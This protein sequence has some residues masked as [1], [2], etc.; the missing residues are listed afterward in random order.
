MQQ[1]GRL[2]RLLRNDR[3][4]LAVEQHGEYFEH[5]GVEIHRSDQRTDAAGIDVQRLGGSDRQPHHSAMFD[6]HA[7]GLPGRSGGVDDV[8][9]SVGGYVGQGGS[10]FH[11]AFGG[12]DVFE[13]IEPDGAQGVAAGCVSDDAA[14]GGIFGEKAQAIRWVAWVKRD[15][16][17][18]EFEDGKH[19]G[20][21]RITLLHRKSDPAAG[22]HVTRQTGGQAVA[23]VVQRT[24]A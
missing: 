11:F 17:A 12:I 13:R 14:H 15:V 9:Q 16:G 22:C 6:H 2:A 24:V 8:S 19:T 7:L 18:A 20:N 4:R 3:K 1:S 23:P 5:A 21:Q 10:R